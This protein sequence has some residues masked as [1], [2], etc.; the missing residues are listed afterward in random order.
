[1]TRPAYAWSGPILVALGASALAATALFAKQSPLARWILVETLAPARVLPLVGMSVAF[2]LLGAPILILSL[3]LFVVGVGSGLYTEDLLLWALDSVPGAA[4]HSFLT[5]PISYLVA[6]LALVVGARWRAGMAPVSAAIFGAMLGL[7]VRLTD[8]SLHVPAYT[9]TPVLIAFW[10][11]V[12]VT[13]TLRAMR[14]T[15]FDIFGRILGSWLIAIGVLYGGAS[16]IPKRNPPEVAVPP[17]TAP[18][19]KPAIP[20]LPLPGQPTQFPNGN[21]DNFRQP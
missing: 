4:T 3:T 1:M 13:L 11:V 20:G 17:T 2:A 5:D 21:S 14:R 16:L 18:G 9:W 10:I 7:S 6:G 12:A 19:G 15:W 8:P